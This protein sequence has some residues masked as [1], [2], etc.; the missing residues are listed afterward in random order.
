MVFFLFVFVNPLEEFLYDPTCVEEI[1]LSKAVTGY[2]GNLQLGIRNKFFT[3]RV[4]RYCSGLPREVVES[5]SLEVFK[6][7]LNLALAT[8]V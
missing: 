1:L 8:M 3:E 2:Q 4:V 7:I 5:S 6:E